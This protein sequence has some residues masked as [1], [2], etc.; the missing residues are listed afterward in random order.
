[1]GRSL[2]G[3]VVWRGWVRGF[4][5]VGSGA[6]QVVP[7]QGPK[8][9]WAPFVCLHWCLGFFNGAQEHPQDQHGDKNL[10]LNV[11]FYGHLI[12]FAKLTI[13]GKVITLHDFN[14]S[15]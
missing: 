2:G 10:L 9:S 8:R 1:M 5:Q 3:G 7:S 15:N 4:E 12:R 13:G 14:V 11:W 6:L